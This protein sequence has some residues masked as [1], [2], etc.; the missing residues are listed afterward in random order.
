M[1]DEI[2]TAGTSGTVSG[3]YLSLLEAVTTLAFGQ[4]M[5]WDVLHEFYSKN[6]VG[7]DEL[8]EGANKPDLRGLVAKFD[9]SLREILSDRKSVV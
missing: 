1:A 3:T 8:G 7:P 4:R 2:D 6:D 5:D 9:L